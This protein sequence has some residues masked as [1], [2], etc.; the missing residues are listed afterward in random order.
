MA[1][2]VQEEEKGMYERGD[3]GGVLKSAAVTRQGEVRKLPRSEEIGGAA[4][5]RFFLVT[6]GEI[7]FDGEAE[8]C[9]SS[10]TFDL[11]LRTN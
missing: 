9:C 2:C 8:Q 1:D 10:V 7:S 6:A 5:L 3:G 11:C 4:F